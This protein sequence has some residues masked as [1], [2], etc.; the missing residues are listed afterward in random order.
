MVLPESSIRR[1]R[2]NWQLRR[3]S[4]FPG[5]PTLRWGALAKYILYQTTFFCGKLL[6]YVFTSCAVVRH[7]LPLLPVPCPEVEPVSVAG[8]DAGG[9][10]D[11]CPG[12]L[13][14]VPEKN[15]SLL[16]GA[17]LLAER[18]VSPFLTGHTL[19]V[20]TSPPFFTHVFVQR[21]FTLFLRKK[22]F[23]FTPPRKHFF[24]V[25]M[26]FVSTIK[27]TTRRTPNLP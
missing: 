10:V 22:V 12:A 27:T 21:L 6:F 16:Y 24:P 2:R 7:W 25:E 17:S 18:G 23:Y 14:G 3:L 1:V 9:V 4:V 26:K 19:F 5:S 8:E 11:H 15:L 13:A 20:Q